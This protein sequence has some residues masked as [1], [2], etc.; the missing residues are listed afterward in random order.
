MTGLATPVTQVARWNNIK[1]VPAEFFTDNQEAGKS[2]AQSLLEGQRQVARASALT[3][4]AL[5]PPG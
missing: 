1:V 2:D 5:S 4:K 3:V